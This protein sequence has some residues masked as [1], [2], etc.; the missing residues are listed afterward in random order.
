MSSDVARRGYRSQ[1]PLSTHLM[2]ELGIR[3]HPEYAVLAGPSAP[4]PSL[5]SS[6]SGLA[7]FEPPRS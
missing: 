3:P 7:R 5:G 6:A 2:T 1:E 4:S